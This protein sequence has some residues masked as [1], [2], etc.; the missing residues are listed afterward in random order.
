MSSFPSGHAPAVRAAVASCTL[1]LLLGMAPS[2]SAV[3]FS[4]AAQD[5][6][7]SWV[8]ASET[9]GPQNFPETNGS[10]ACWG[11][12][13]GD[14][15]EDIFFVNGLYQDADM[16]QALDPRSALYLNTGLGAFV[17][18]SEE[19]NADLSG[20]GQGCALVDYDSDSDTDIMVT[21]YD[22]IV[23]LRNEG[24]H[25][26]DVTAASGFTLDDKCD[27]APYCFAEANTW[28]DYDGD[29][30]LD[31]YITQYGDYDIDVGGPVGPG[32]LNGMSN[33]LWRNNGDG[34]FT[35]VT[36]LA[37]VRDNP[38]PSH[39]KSFQ[40]A[41]ADFDRDGLL[42][43]YITSDTTRNTLYRNN[44]DGTF[45]DVSAQAG[46]DDSGAS[47]GLVFQDINH[48]GLPDL[49]F[50]HYQT[51]S[52][53]Y[54][55]NDGDGTFTRHSG[56][57][58]LGNDL[59]LVSWGTALGDFGNDG[60]RDLLVVN[61]H[62]APLRDHSQKML[63]FEGAGAGAFID[64]SSAAG[65]AFERTS[66]ARGSAIGDADLDGD[67]DFV[68][69]DHFNNTARLVQ[70]D[71]IGN[72]FLQVHLIGSSINRNAIGAEV[73][74]TPAIGPTTMH[75]VQSGS[76][77]LSQDSLIVHAG[78][79]AALSADVDVR[80]PD[81]TI[82]SWTAL[83]A[84]QR[85]T[86][87]QGL[88]GIVTD[89][90][91]PWTNL[92]LDGP[93]LAGGWFNDIVTISIDST[94]RGVGGGTGVAGQELDIGAGF[95]PYAGAVA[96]GADGNHTL[97][98]R[99]TD[100]AGNVEPV[101]TTKIGIDR[102]AP[103]T[104]ASVHGANQSAAGWYPEG[105]TVTLDATDPLAGVH[106]TWAR[107][108]GGAWTVATSVSL[109]NSGT[110][111]VEYY[112]TDRA[113]NVGDVGTVTVHV[114]IDVPTIS[115][116]SATSMF[117]VAPHEVFVDAIDNHS[118]ID[119]VA[120]YRGDAAQPFAVDSDAS[121][122]YSVVL[123][124]PDS[125]QLRAVAVDAAGHSAQEARLTVVAPELPDLPELPHMVLFPLIG[126]LVR[127]RRPSL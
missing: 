45:A 119:F 84:N 97:R 75:T 125:F 88:P 105:A 114:D 124:G 98:Y 26:V 4:D 110:Y 25:F 54:Y 63:L 44:G 56:E 68:V 60:T 95:V 101:R 50:T 87:T 23:L 43:L 77:F 47:M 17:D 69:V 7:I 48:D 117:G 108:N 72:G 67:L 30:D 31:V 118:G 74:I 8:H 46:V 115:F 53:G 85:I 51:E 19:W 116:S 33:M 39:S 12:V 73:T 6:G 38:G 61:G 94:D 18:V 121:D 57:G 24:D 107:I 127:M 104:I 120:F 103:T 1:L 86:L 9:D 16:T 126:G 13:D 80:W 65:S 55:L 106:E 28:A 82:Q 102:T 71:G 52:N 79:G 96:L 99:A 90:I 32:A 10:G 62:T 41:W 100:G 91:S 70:N 22:M 123:S 93:T 2:A 111:V 122:G 40:S 5:L 3:T 81:G 37:G 112:S 15:V 49:Y 64:T 59:D 14:G 113:S 21:G 27:G 36:D 11:D 89:A 58:D 109:N 20:W 66:I 34:T 92:T 29:G 78:L 35:D 42:D 83:A 76:N